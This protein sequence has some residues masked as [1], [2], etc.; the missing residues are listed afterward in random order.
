VGQ[1]HCSVVNSVSGNQVVHSWVELN[2]AGFSDDAIQAQLSARR[3]Q[4]VGRAVVQHN[5]PLTR[6]QRWLVARLHAGP[7]ALLTAFTAAQWLGL[8]GWERTE[9]HILA[10]VGTRARRIDSGPVRLHFALHWTDVRQHGRSVCHDLPDALLRAAATFD[11]ARPACG[12]LAASV[13]QRLVTPAALRDSLARASRTRHR[14][15]LLSA[16][17]DIEQGSEALSEIDFLALCRRFSLPEPERQTVR[18]DS[19]GRRRYLDATWRRSDGR[20]VVVEIDGALHLAQK[21]WWDDQ[22]RQNEL[23]LADALV[24]R[25]PS[26]VVRTE[27]ELVAAQLRRA[28]LLP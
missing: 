9:T 25:F 18:R 7:R 24:L 3:W 23:S 16:V 1:R 19:T 5:G 22:L 15:I 21:R 8:N 27:P 10:P 11:S 26:V 20:L 12:I 17:A 4:R 2:R 13:Q 14:A 28:L 6:S